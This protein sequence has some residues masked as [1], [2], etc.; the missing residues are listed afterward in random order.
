MEATGNLDGS[1]GT[2]AGN[3]AVRPTPSKDPYKPAVPP[4]QHLFLGT[5]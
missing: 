1:T 2:A 5:Q 3:Y 4:L